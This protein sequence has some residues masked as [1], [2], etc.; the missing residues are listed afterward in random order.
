MSATWRVGIVGAGLMA[1]GFDAPGSPRVL[2]MAH[3]F[4]RV[5]RF[6]VSGFFDQRP[7]RAAAAEQRWGVPSTP[8]ERAAWFDQRWDVIYIA[9]PDAQHAGD[10]ET[11][12]DARPRAV[13]VEKPLA[14]D[15]GD[16]AQLL[17]RAEREGVPL[18]VN[19]PRRHHSAVAALRRMVAAGE[20]SAPSSAWAAVS[21]GAAHNLP[22]LI[23]LV[24]A[25]WGSGWVVS[26]AGRRGELVTLRWQRA[27][28]TFWMCVAERRAEYYV[29]EA[30][31][32]C[33]E[34]KLELSKSPEVLEWSAPA[35]HPDYASY[36]VLHPRLSAGMEDEPLL[37]RAVASLAGVLDDPAAAA[38]A[39]AIERETQRLVAAALACFEPE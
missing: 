14:L 11:A 17:D 7:E 34:G 36:R 18:I 9:T 1:Q 31:F 23:D 15:A 16:A 20:L 8:R 4:A 12:L 2:S 3:A 39:L 28:E 19:F 21:G 38:A 22:H 6:S 27:E 24:R 10:L 32:H 26:G 30:Q 5:P 37:T 33:P 35:P 25:V 29:W 13:L